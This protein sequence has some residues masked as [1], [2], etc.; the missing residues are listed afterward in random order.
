[1]KFLF[2]LAAMGMA[3]SPVFAASHHCMSPV[4]AW[5]PRSLLQE[6]LEDEGW[7][8]RSIRAQDGCYDARA[9]DPQG[10][11]VQAFFDPASLE[12]LDVELE[13]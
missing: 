11:R 4:A 6:K 1:M 3:A 8:V 13:P 7:H 10:Q 12:R 5:K 2:A 9:I